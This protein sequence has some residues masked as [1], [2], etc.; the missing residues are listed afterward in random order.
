MSHYL[1][2]IEQLVVLQKVD[3]EIF[4]IRKEVT[5][6]PKELEGLQ[7]K[8]TA[9]TEERNHLLDKMAHL[10]DQAKR[11]DFD[12]DADLGKIKKSKNK[13]MQV[14]NAKEYSAMM[15]EMDSLEKNNRSR[16]EERMILAEELE[17]QNA[18]MADLEPRYTSTQEELES[19]QNGFDAHMAATQE[20]LGVLDKQ[21]IA[22]SSEVP[23]PV[24]NR[25]EF[26][27]QRLAYPVIVSVKN[28]V[29]SGC[30]IAI[31]PQ[32]YI[33]LQKGAQI[34]SCPNCQRLI[35]WDEHFA[36]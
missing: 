26:I 2:Q 8:F 22:S 29:C 3:G 27:R 5:N 16:E 6:A 23:A 9:L 1:K 30:N 18:A 24:L 14:G 12:I 4:A 13:L 33:E 17:R 34:L 25:Y 11:L 32:T 21:R 35:Y 7:A 10:K 28:G 31:P 20:Q 15:R 19:K 36:A